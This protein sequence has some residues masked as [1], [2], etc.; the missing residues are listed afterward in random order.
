[1]KLIAFVLILITHHAYSFTINMDST[2]KIDDVNKLLKMKL[3]D[4]LESEL[5]KKGELL[6]FGLYLNEFKINLN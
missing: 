2:K 5:K 6:L 1:M 4:E 3:F